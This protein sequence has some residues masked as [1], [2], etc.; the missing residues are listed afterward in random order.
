MAVVF[1]VQEH[2]GVD[3]PESIER[4]K[5]VYKE[6]ELET[7]FK[8]YEEESYRRISDKIEDATKTCPEIP[9]AVFTQLLGKIY[10]RQK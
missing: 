10:K 6:L 2:Y 3:K 8:N 9:S 5:Q 7:L 1:A 4:V